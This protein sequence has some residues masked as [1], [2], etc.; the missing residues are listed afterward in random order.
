MVTMSLDGHEVTTSKLKRNG[1]KCT[2]T[3]DGVELDLVNPTTYFELLVRTKTGQAVGLLFFKLAWIFDP[4][5]SKL[6]VEQLSMEPDGLISLEL[7]YIAK[8]PSSTQ[9]YSP[10]L[11]DLARQNAIQRKRIDKLGHI[12]L[13]KKSYNLMKCAVCKEFS[14]QTTAYKCEF[15]RFFCHKK[16]INLILTKC[17]AAT[18]GD[19]E[20]QNPLAEIKYDMEHCFIETQSIIPSWCMHC[21]KYGRKDFLKCRACESTCHQR[22][23]HNIPNHC[24]MPTSIPEIAALRLNRQSQSR[25][26]VERDTEMAVDSLENYQILKLIG[27]GNFGKVVLA[28]QIPTGLLVAIKAIPKSAVEENDEIENIFIERDI[29]KITNKESHPF[30]VQLVSFFE[31]GKNFYFVMEYIAGGDLMFHIQKQRFTEYQAKYFAAQILLAIEYL[32]KH[33]ILYRDLKL[34]NIM[35]TADGHVKLTDF[36]LCKPGMDWRAQTKTFCGTPEFIAPEILS[37]KPY[38]KAVDWWAYGVLLYEL[39]LGQ[40]PFGGRNEAEVFHS[41]MAGRVYFPSKISP[42]AKDLIQR[43]LVRNPKLRLGYGPN[44]SGPIRKHPFFRDI[45]FDRLLMRLDQSPYIPIIRHASVASNFDP[46]FTKE[47]PDII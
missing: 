42:E 14:Y 1:E 9:E 38:T 35:L 34:D 46:T 23:V 28:K 32:H 41:I 40:S 17:V 16:C 5:Q 20:G 13:A 47:Q 15:C 44:D 45:N 21:G 2:L 7:E 11:N 29:F 30:L 24:G 3:T 18:D 25:S 39:I 12:L 8:E 43:L 6:F 33:E 4:N 31:D 26:L 19:L 10:S 22:C 37:S 36:G 27:K